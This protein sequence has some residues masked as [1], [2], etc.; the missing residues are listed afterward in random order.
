MGIDMSNKRKEKWASRRNGQRGSIAIMFLAA[1][2]VMCGFFGLALDLSQLY[3]R[4]VEMQTVADTVAVAAALELNG[5][6]AGVTRALQRASERLFN[7]P[8]DDDGRGFI[9]V[10][11]EDD[12]LVSG[13]N[14]VRPHTERAMAFCR[15]G[16]GATCRIALCKSRHTWT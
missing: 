6:A 9:P 8:G 7:L 10:L 14:R 3:N 16:V 2:L 12:G 4:K 11:D 1:F 15:H 5:T 13:C